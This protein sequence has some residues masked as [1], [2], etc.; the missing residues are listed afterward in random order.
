M[1]DFCRSVSQLPEITMNTAI[2]MMNLRRFD[3]AIR[4][5]RPLALS[6]HE[7]LSAV[8]LRLMAQA[9][10][11]RNGACGAPGADSREED[12]PAEGDPPSSG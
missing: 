9:Q 10:E 3:D 5:L 11:R 12:A 2:M 4:I 6:P 7:G 8:A 1:A